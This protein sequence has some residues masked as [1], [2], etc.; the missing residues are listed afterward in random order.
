MEYIAWLNFILL[1]SNY[2]HTDIYTGI[3]TSFSF[4]TIIC[5]IS[6]LFLFIHFHFTIWFILFH[7]ASFSFILSSFRFISYS[8][9]LHFAP[10]RFIS[11]HFASFRF[12]SY[13]SRTEFFLKKTQNF[14]VYQ[15][16]FT[17]RN[18]EEK[19]LQIF[20]FVASQFLVYISNI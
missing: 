6:L 11:L 9:R 2:K 3:H 1:E 10:F 4:S 12:I 14:G 18:F 8:F 16:R 5:F 20:Y 19:A 15:K 13:F 7:L 17:G